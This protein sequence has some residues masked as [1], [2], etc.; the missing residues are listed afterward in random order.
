VVAAADHEE[1][2][3]SQVQN[4]AYSMHW[5]TE[6]KPTAEAVGFLE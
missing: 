2:K 6:K 3:I 4:N 5:C 1:K